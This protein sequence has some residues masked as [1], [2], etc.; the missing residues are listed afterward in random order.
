M[1]KHQMQLEGTGRACTG[2]WTSEVS[3][4]AHSDLESSRNETAFGDVEEGKLVVTAIRAAEET[5]KAEKTE[6]KLSVQSAWLG[7]SAGCW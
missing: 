1:G 2:P 5:S 3:I 7:P 6:S 4:K